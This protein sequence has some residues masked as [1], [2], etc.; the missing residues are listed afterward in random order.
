MLF[1]IDEIPILY[2]DTEILVLNKPA[3]IAVIPERYEEGELSLLELLTERVGIPGGQNPSPT[4]LQDQEPAG[5][6]RNVAQL[7]NYKSSGN[8]KG[9]FLSIDGGDEESRLDTPVPQ[10]PDLSTPPDSPL[11]P[12]HRIDKETS[13]IVLFAKT[14]EAFR[15]LSLQF[16]ERTLTKIYHALVVGR[17]GWVE[18]DCD[19]PLLVDGDRRHRTIVHREGKPSR[20]FL[21][22]LETFREFALVEAQPKTGRTHQIRAH[23][24]YMGHPIVG[25]A[26]YRGGEGLYLS[27]FKRGY[28]GTS[29]FSA[30]SKKGGGREKEASFSVGSPQGSTISQPVS[31][32]KPL[33]GRLALHAV[34]L[35]CRH[36]RT[37]ELLR[38]EAPYPKDFAVALKQLR[39]YGKE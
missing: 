22:V 21:K 26:L 37:G 7:R 8:A 17:P 18:Q 38:F 9:R 1:R 19:V 23:L 31:K 20:T 32:E 35:E 11:R 13:G 5:S 39:K 34:S 2:E 10:E 25:D 33:I 24:S 36:P 15:G 6:G 29:F 14:E 16:Q 27:A 30:P 3:G 4:R 12:V 28:K